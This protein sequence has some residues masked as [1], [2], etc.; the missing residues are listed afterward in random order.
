MSVTKCKDCGGEI[1]FKENELCKSCYLKFKEK[2][3]KCKSCGRDIDWHNY[4]LHS[5]LCDDCDNPV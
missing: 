4:H 5:Q 1:D 3:L 2:A